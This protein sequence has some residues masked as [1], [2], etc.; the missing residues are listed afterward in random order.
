MTI[1][2]DREFISSTRGNSYEIVSHQD[3]LG[4]E[5]LPDSPVV[6]LV[7]NPSMIGPILIGADQIDEAEECAKGHPTPR[8]ATREYLSPKRV[9]I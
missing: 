2:I 9:V 8:D 6:P 7:M 3:V 5:L 1:S 4:N